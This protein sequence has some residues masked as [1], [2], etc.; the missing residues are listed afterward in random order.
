[1]KLNVYSDPQHGWCK[2]KRSLLVKL[3]ID[4]N[5]SSF[6]YVRGDYVYLE[7]DRDMTIFITAMNNESIKFSFKETHGNRS[8]RIRNYDRYVVIDE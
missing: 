4:K 2:V 6:S 5:I 1:M 3:G 7:E 8:S